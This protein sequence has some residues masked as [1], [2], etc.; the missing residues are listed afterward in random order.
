MSVPERIDFDRSRAILIGTSAY[1]EGLEPMPAAANSL[2]HMEDM[3][4]GHCGWPSA[5]VAPFRDLS[6]GDRRRREVNT[7]IGEATDVLLLYYVGHGLLLP[8]DDLGLAL[9]DTGTSPALHLTTTYPLGTLRGQLRYHCHARLKLII[10]DCCFSGIAI[11]NAQGPGGGLADRVDH[12]SRIEG[13]YTWTASRASQQAVHEDGDGGLTYF[14]KILH[15]VVAAG[16]PGKSDWLT[17]ADV[18]FAVAQRFR[19]LPL[20]DT[21]IRPEPTRLAVGDLP[22]MFPFAPNRA[23]T[24]VPPGASRRRTG[25]ASS[26]PEQAGPARAARAPGGEAARGDREPGQSGRERAGAASTPASRPSSAVARPSRLA[27]TLT[28]AA[29]VAFSPDGR[30]LASCGKDNT[31]RLWNPATG[32]ELRTLTADRAAR[33]SQSRRAERQPATVLGVA[34]SPDGQMLAGCGYG[35]TIWLW[36]PATGGCLHTINNRLSVPVYEV[37]FSPDGRTLASCGIDKVR[38]LDPSTGA[39]QRPLAGKRRRILVGIA[40]RVAFSPDGQMLAIGEDKMLGL[41][42]PAT[43]KCLRTLTGHVKVHGELL[44]QLDGACRVHDVAFSPDGQTLASSGDDKM[45]RLW[46]PATGKCLRTLTDV[47]KVYGVAFSPDGRT[48]ASCA[49]DKIRLWDPAT[50]ECL[51]TLTDVGKAYRV[52]FSPD[53]RTLASCGESWEEDNTVRLWD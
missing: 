47:G 41:W 18:D 9:T 6:T 7:L 1:T 40:S 25:S 29:G 16:I 39:E 50:G 5:A 22:G 38:L 46:D 14:T 21:P 27:R 11:R 15:E 49:G 33:T 24:P 26:G 20:P 45:V 2:R 43:G 48:L 4:T 37:A 34:F 13:T 31:V 36:D 42:D 10:L 53:G 30:T 12:V 28:G 44:R 32:A 23:F 51:R 3:L 52:A 8:G 17:L 19:E 35:G